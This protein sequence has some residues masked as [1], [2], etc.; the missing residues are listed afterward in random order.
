MLLFILFII[1]LAWGSRKWLHNAPTD[2]ARKFRA[3][4]LWLFGI[5]LLLIISRGNIG[6]AITTIGTFVSLGLLRTYFEHLQTGSPHDNSEKPHAS[7]TRRPPSTGRMTAVE[8]YEVLGLPKGA[9]RDEIVTA[10]R[11]L[12]QRLHPDRGGSDYL[13]AKIN[14]AK[15][16]LLG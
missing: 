6:A 10:H 3:A 5:L 9:S 2:L 8:A 14:Q 4:L 7:R 1:A 11:R 15:D 13:A 12:M 16:V